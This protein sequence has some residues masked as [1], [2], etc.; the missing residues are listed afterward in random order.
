[1]WK[2]DIHPGY[3]TRQSLL[4]EHRELHAIA[5]I[6]IN[7][8]KGYSRHPETLRWLDCRLALKQ[9][10]CLLAAEMQLRGYREKSPLRMRTNRGVWPERYIDEP[11]QQFAILR[12]KYRNGKQQG[13]IPLPE[14]DQ[15][16][17]SNHKY[18]ILAR[19]LALYKKVGRKVSILKNCADY[20]QFAMTLAEQLRIPPSQGGIRNA[21]QHMWGYVS[22]CNPG[23]GERVELWSPGRL[24]NEIQMRAVDNQVQYLVH[25]TALSELE[26]WL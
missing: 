16:L 5:S 10:H 9:R 14:N 6:I 17:C 18:S 4:G 12:D 25:S 11:F 22:D 8:K 15:Q 23:A 3:L 26:G 20:F 2:W 1:M 24:L 13:R 19:N 7:K 21:L